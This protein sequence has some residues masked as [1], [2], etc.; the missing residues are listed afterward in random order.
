MVASTTLLGPTSSRRISPLRSTI[1]PIIHDLRSPLTSSVSS[2][3]RKT[4]GCRCSDV[5]GSKE[6]CASLVTSGVWLGVWIWRGVGLGL[7][8]FHGNFCSS[9]CY[10]MQIPSHLR[11]TRVIRLLRP[12][13]YTSTRTPCPSPI[14]NRQSPPPHS[15][16][17]PSGK[18][19]SP[20]P[21]TPSRVSRNR[22]FHQHILWLQHHFVPGTSR[23]T[24]Y[25]TT[26]RRADGGSRNQ[27][28]GLSWVDAWEGTTLSGCMGWL[29]RLDVGDWKEDWQAGGDGHRVCV[30]YRHRM[31]GSGSWGFASGLSWKGFGRSE[32]YG[33]RRETSGRGRKQ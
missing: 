25:F 11:F 16:S 27:S 13:H 2:F 14:A 7:R 21:N 9:R 6:G 5:R 23:W 30:G 20:P 17:M 29:R 33:S 12:T 4:T 10:C 31:N 28:A 24:L 19:S 1:P 15:T 3:D 26:R 18:A 8:T 32:R 22:G